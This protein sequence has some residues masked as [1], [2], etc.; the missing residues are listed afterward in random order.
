MAEE[1]D[2]HDQLVKAWTKFSI[3]D[4]WLRAFMMEFEPTYAERSRVSK[5]MQGEYQRSCT[6]T[7]WSEWLAL[8]R[9]YADDRRTARHK[10]EFR[11]LNA[12]LVV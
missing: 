10:T 5:V 4:R 7:S 12:N 11:F 9:H 6:D 2:A 1:Q 8:N 3:A